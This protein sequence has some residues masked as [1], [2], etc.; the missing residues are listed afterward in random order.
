MQ[1]DGPEGPKIDHPD[2]AAV[3]PGA[4]PVPGDAPAPAAPLPDD[5][6]TAQA[7]DDIAA[8][9]SDELLKAEDKE[10]QEAF[11]G[12]PKS[13]WDKV[14][15]WLKDYWADPKKRWATIGGA[16]VLVITLS[17][18]P[19]SRYFMLNTVG[20]RGSASIT[21][22]DGSTQQPLK[23]V[24]VSLKGKSGLTN[25]QGQARLTGLKLGNTDLVVSK[26]AFAS[27]K[28]PITVGWGSNP[29]GQVAVKAVGTQ[30]AF[31]VVDW[32]SDKPL[33]K[34][35]AAYKEA[36]ALSDADGQQLLTLD[37]E[38]LKDDDKITVTFS[39]ADYRTEKVEVNLDSKDPP[40]V[41]LVPARKEV[42][43]SK[44]SGKY[45]LYKVDLDGKNESL[46]LPGTG[47]ERDD[48][49]LVTHPTE[50]L[51]AFIST[52]D[53]LRNS[54]GYLL[55]TLS[56]IDLNDNAR[57]SVSQSERIQL[58][59]WQGDKLIYVQVAAGAS[60]ANPRRQR[61]V[62]YDTDSGSRQEIASAN[63]FNDILLAQGRIYYAPASAFQTESPRLFRVDLD[64]S[65]RQTLMNSEIYNIFR[66]DYDTLQLSTNK[67]W[68]EYKLT[69]SSL[70]QLAGSPANLINRLYLDS[71]DKSLS[72]WVD[73]RDGKGVLLSYNL[74]SKVDK[75]LLS[76]SGLNYPISW[77]S[78]LA[79][80]FRIK[81]DQET[82][83]YALSLNGG[84]AKKIRDVTN[85]QGLSR[86]YYY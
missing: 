37:P 2:P 51:A 25:S 57:L 50:P 72:L 29:L 63:Y 82:A 62:S 59:G 86:W 60:A 79:A 33:A 15:A 11:N 34:A 64:G 46:V 55:S 20:V 6:K 22:L 19:A 77:V 27:Y 45:D 73:Q 48:M 8:K 70:R 75:N 7:I 30:Y 84:Q 65:N 49:A 76:R 68:Y 66:S 58:I 12:Q 36:S 13:R 52:R 85:T 31:R 83:D 17:S 78:N 56:L 5:P 74:D 61:L 43:V 81:T 47:S 14:K 18:I 4:P 67:D 21:V 53:N 44:R 24:K 23:N 41:Q 16:A 40:T 1:D 42:F 32:L 3:K 71:G 28:K 69:G 26:R 54:D 80:I 35:E 38:D 10:V 9:D 39:A